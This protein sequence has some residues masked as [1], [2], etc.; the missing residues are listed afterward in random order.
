MGVRPSIS[1]SFTQSLL[2]RSSSLDD[3][4]LNS[5]LPP[6]TSNRE[7]ARWMGNDPV[8]SGI[9]ALH[10]AIHIETKSM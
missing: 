7:Q 5:A 2:L 4:A 8:A 9:F 6:L 10:P 3:S 1:S